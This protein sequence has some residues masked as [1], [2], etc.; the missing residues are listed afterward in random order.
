M[1]IFRKWG[2]T[3]IVVTA[4]MYA[5][6]PCAAESLTVTYHYTGN[7]FHPDEISGTPGIFTPSDKVTASFTVNCELAHDAGD[8]RNLPYQNYYALGAVDT[9]SVNFAA[10]PAKLPTAR[11]FTNIQR[12]SFSTDSSGHIVQ[13]DMD[14]F[15]PDVTGILNVDTD[16]QLDSAT[17]EGAGATTFGRPGV[18]GISNP[19]FETEK[20]II[21]M[22]EPVNSMTHSGIGNLRGWAIAE[23]GIDRVEIY[24]DGKYAYDAPFGG[25]RGDVGAKYPDVPDAANSGFSL[26][27]SHS[28]I[29]FGEHNITARAFDQAGQWKDTT[30]TFNVVTFDKKYISKDDV[31]DTSNSDITSEG[32]EIYIEDIVIGDRRYDLTLKWRT[33]EQGFEIIEIR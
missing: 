8:C 31:V 26:A 32:D 9:T 7:N 6:L 2:L 5:A 16:N 1:N 23:F 20:I 17:A 24:I 13:W 19:V 30:V 14:L 27:F 3:G 29:G 22:D 33:Q 11:G 15:W 12:F 4:L 25:K 21:N 28:T 18:W 10:G